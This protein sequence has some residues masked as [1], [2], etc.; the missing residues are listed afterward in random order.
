MIPEP[1]LTENQKFL[2]LMAAG[3]AFD[4]AC[5]ETESGYRV[6]LRTKNKCGIAW[7]G[8]RWIVAEMK[9]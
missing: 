3:C 7:D 4:T 8:Q 2:L 6:V 9:P 5:E 1:T